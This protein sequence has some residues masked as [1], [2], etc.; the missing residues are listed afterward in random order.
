MGQT[1]LD[2]AFERIGRRGMAARMQ[3]TARSF[4]KKRE[5]P[6]GMRQPSLCQ[7]DTLLAA[8]GFRGV[9]MKRP[10]AQTR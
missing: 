6:K 3:Q 8:S 1:A 4:Q 7:S 9:G 5:L 2:K 10:K